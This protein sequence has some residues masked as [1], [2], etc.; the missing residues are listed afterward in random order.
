MFPPYVLV[1]KKTLL[2]VNSSHISASW[3]SEFLQLLSR[4]VSI[5]LIDINRH[6]SPTYKQHELLNEQLRILYC[7]L[8]TDNLSQ[9]F[10][11]A[12][13]LKLSEGVLLC[14][15][16]FHNRVIECLQLCLE[17][18]CIQEIL[19]IYREEL[20]ERAA[21]RLNTSGEIHTHN[22]IY[23]LA[24]LFYG[25]SPRNLHDPYVGEL[26]IKRIEKIL[27]HQFN[28]SYQLINQLHCVYQH[29]LKTLTEKYAYQGSC[30]TGYHNDVYSVWLAYLSEILE[31]SP[32]PNFMKT[33]LVMN[34]DDQ[35][36]NLNWQKVTERILQI[37]LDNDAIEFIDEKEKKL[38][39]EI[40]FSDRTAPL[41]DSMIQCFLAVFLKNYHFSHMRL[42]LF[43]I[44]K[45]F[46]MQYIE[47]H[48][49][50]IFD[51]LS[52]DKTSQSFFHFIGECLILYQGKL[53]FQRDI[54]DSSLY[55][56]DLFY[57]LIA[58]H[59][60]FAANLFQKILLKSE[61]LNLS[62]Y[63]DL[64][65]FLRTVLFKGKSSLFMVAFQN[66]Y[67]Y[68]HLFFETIANI[69][70]KAIKEV[71]LLQFIDIELLFEA[72]RSKSTA[73]SSLLKL[74]EMIFLAYPQYF[75]LHF[76]AANISH[77]NILMMFAQYYPDGLE[78][79]LDFIQF[80]QN[81]LNSLYDEA[82]L[83]P[84]KFMLKN[85]MIQKNA[86]QE[87][88]LSLLEKHLPSRL[89]LFHKAVSIIDDEKIKKSILNEM[90]LYPVSIS[91]NPLIISVTRS[92]DAMK[93][94]LDL[95]KTVEDETFFPEF[96]RSIFL[97]QI[98]G[99]NIF[100]Q[101]AKNQDPLASILYLLGYADN[102]IAHEENKNL[103]VNLFIEFIEAEAFIVDLF[104]RN[105]IIINFILNYLKTMIDSKDFSSYVVSLFMSKNEK[106][107]T[108]IENIIRY[109]PHHILAFFNALCDFMPVN[110]C[111]SFIHKNK[112]ILFD[113]LNYCAD[114]FQEVF[115]I[116]TDIFLGNEKDNFISSLLFL[117][118][119]EGA[120]LL[121]LAA[122][123]SEEHALFIL[124]QL[125]K[126][127]QKTGDISLFEAVL[128]KVNHLGK[129]FLMVC[130]EF[131]PENIKFVD[132]IYFNE[133]FLGLDKHK[134]Q[135][136]IKIFILQK[137]TRGDNVFSLL[138]KHHPEK[139]AYFITFIF[140][141][142]K[143]IF[144]DILYTE[145]LSIPNQ[146]SGRNALTMMVYEYPQAIAPFLEAT[147]TDLKQAMFVSLLEQA[148]SI[149]VRGR[150]AL[151]L[152]AKNQLPALKIFFDMI[153]LVEDKRKKAEF[154][155]KLFYQKD[156]DDHHSL[157][158]F[159]CYYPKAMPYL[160][161]CFDS[162][163]LTDKQKYML[164]SDILSEKNIQHEKNT[165]LLGL[166]YHLESCELLV[167]MIQKIRKPEF[168]DQLLYQQL[169]SRSSLWDESILCFAI[170][171][172][173]SV[174]ELLLNMLGSI[175]DKAMQQAIL[176][177]WFLKEKFMPVLSECFKNSVNVSALTLLL[178]MILKIKPSSER[179]ELLKA[180]LVMQD[181]KNR[182]I[183]MHMIKAHKNIDPLLDMINKISNKSLRGDIIKNAFV[184]S[185]DSEN[186][187]AL[188]YAC[189][190]FHTDLLKLVDLIN[191]KIFSNA[192]NRLPFLTIKLT[193]DT[194]KDFYSTKNDFL[195]LLLTRENNDNEN[196]LMLA[197]RFNEYSI[198]SCFKLLSLIN[199]EFFYQYTLVDMLTSVDKWNRH[200]IFYLMMHYPAYLD[201]LDKALSHIR[202]S[203][204]QD[205]AR[206]ILLMLE[207]PDGLNLLEALLLSGR[208]YLLVFFKI[209]NHIVDVN[210][211][212]KVIDYLLSERSIRE[213]LFDEMKQGDLYL[214]QDFLCF[215]LSV[216]SKKEL[217]KRTLLFYHYCDSKFH[218]IETLF[219]Q[220][221][222]VLKGRLAGD[223]KKHLA[224]MLD[225]ILLPDISRQ[226]RL[227]LLEQLFKFFSLGENLEYLQQKVEKK[228]LQLK[229]I[230]NAFL[231]ACYHKKFVTE[232]FYKQHCENLVKV[233]LSFLQ[234]REPRRA[235]SFT[236]DSSS[237]SQVRFEK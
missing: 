226:D 66:K 189:K 96:I 40:F 87:N 123:Q 8:K 188:M 39:T 181:A 74:Y 57:Y 124:D 41:S 167:Q 121:H 94:F 174:L 229:K 200:K 234:Q 73:L 150:N 17:P 141:I 51:Y 86:H 126:L 105:P 210:R 203:E 159:V 113:V 218:Q 71:V 136:F 56:Y 231:D 182:N 186:N 194:V 93:N 65:L 156:K 158:F 204:L 133:Q 148:F 172:D 81:H 217:E 185:V 91:I 92:R 22:Y 132:W 180:V 54:S 115:Y 104:S 50:K 144:Q 178:H 214:D 10:F 131:F 52:R 117:E 155:D 31:I 70:N 80:M 147:P 32:Y 61:G 95:F 12:V 9:D 228:I 2:S 164:L 35:V 225:L 163:G 24:S 118:N 98:D 97:K 84:R 46:P 157:D 120:S 197:M 75:S 129:N 236:E 235:V 45:L 82:S 101:A 215:A 30:L 36:I 198:P 19:T 151:M 146:Y 211:R 53:P 6:L 216:R 90:M 190:Y 25:I 33:Y 176:K 199:H 142:N 137:D 125:F 49:Q 145:C 13:A 29:L 106:N 191:Q 28:Q 1:N 111:V 7:Y 18:T 127:F 201:N 135:H 162:Y 165:F 206:E 119:I 196:L 114:S 222:I 3:L 20:V 122:R 195:T 44:K 63:G 88:F 179:D 187:N 38:F 166:S 230:D 67:E 14:S 78:N 193:Q 138:L 224:L 103:I 140:K 79:I 69:E 130:A 232:K 4:T 77:N 100:M 47:I 72:A 23:T 58:H 213:R 223:E 102:I 202:T 143:T 48:L 116:L 170:K 128:A 134:I 15:P 184:L 64:S 212:I 171:K 76:L 16:G 168:K 192:N 110:A 154:L 161:A 221:F 55:S 85:L 237:T 227:L 37:F 59:S 219:S 62:A 209:V 107:H 160:L 208:E 173:L 108:V 26:K 5:P 207:N 11:A 233:S 60:I 99:E 183:F 109:Y 220:I 149:E 153:M 34:E 205:S 152:A 83:S 177:T 21:I 112:S 139:I 42:I 89:D 169:M 43:Y 175:S 68:I 27:A